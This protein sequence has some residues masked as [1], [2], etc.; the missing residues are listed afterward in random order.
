MTGHIARAVAEILVW[1]AALTA[2]WTVLISSV[3]TLEL[4]V[5]AG[6]ALLSAWAAR[7][8]RRAAVR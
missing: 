7:G 8:A 4:V 2:L 5:G 3:D 6:A 1:W